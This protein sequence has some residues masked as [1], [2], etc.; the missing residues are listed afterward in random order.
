MPHHRAIGPDIVYTDRPDTDCQLSSF[1]PVIRE[2][3]TQLLSNLRHAN[4]TLQ[5]W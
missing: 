4:S 5:I 2:E 3:T 1:L